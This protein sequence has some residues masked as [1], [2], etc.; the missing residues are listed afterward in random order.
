M[1]FTVYALFDE[2]EPDA[3]RYIGFSG[4]P[5][6][7]FRTHVKLALRHPDSQ[8]YKD[9]WLRKVLA[10]K[11]RPL[12]RTLAIVETLQE[13]AEIEIALIRHAKDAGH[14]LTNCTDG[15]EGAEGYGG[16]LTPEVRDRV[17]A[18]HRTPEYRAKRSEQSTQYWLPQETREQHRAFMQSFWQSPEGDELRRKNSEFAKTQCASPDYKG[19]PRTPEAREK[20]RQAKLGKPG[21]PRTEEWKA[22]IAAAQKGKKRRPWTAEERE[23]HMAAAANPETRAKMSASAKARKDRGKKTP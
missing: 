1:P 14:P 2:R 16:F 10:E 20:M 19:G 21:V 18:A 8:S 3:I 6:S 22:K 13:A 9:N 15:G 17:T 5:T 23:R 4:N 7:R 12:W 11:A